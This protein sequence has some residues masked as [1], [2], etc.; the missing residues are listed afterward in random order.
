[1]PA[2]FFIS[3]PVPTD[4]A[5]SSLPVLG[6]APDVTVMPQGLR[7]GTTV[8][9]APDLMVVV[10]LA[11]GMLMDEANR[12]SHAFSA[13]L[14]LLHRQCLLAWRVD[15]LAVATPLIA[16]IGLLQFQLMPPMPPLPPTTPAS[17]T[18]SRAVPLSRFALL[19][20]SEGEWLLESGRSRWVVRLTDAGVSGL[21][22]LS[23]L[24][25]RAAP[26]LAL[27]CATGMLDDRDSEPAARF[28]EPH[29]RYFASRSRIDFSMASCRR[30]ELRPTELE[31]EPGMRAGP[32]GAQRIALPVPVGPQPD[33]PSLWTATETRRTV[34]LFA[35][36]PVSLAALG[37]LLWR[38]LRVTRHLPRDP[39]NPRSYEQIYRPVASGGAMGGSDLW[40]MCMSV[41]G[42]PQGVW[43]YDPFAHELV[44]VAS[45][46]A[47]V[48]RVLIR[49]GATPNPPPVIGLITVRHARA[50]WKYSGITYALELKDIGVILH[51]LQLVAGAVGLGM[52]MWGSGPTEIIT[53][54]LGLDPE[55]DAP[56]GE[57][58]LGVAKPDPH[59]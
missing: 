23:G 12:P 13:A 6:L 34:R 21:A 31:P 57:F 2:A 59:E 10:A 27:L 9:P 44:A 54:L 25:S 8:T 38:T 45:Q 30:A 40:L 37:T 24:G 41:C 14:D 33:E 52:C 16:G 55:V 47:D 29:D 11:S 53:D 28:W 3:R 5:A 17:T 46:P 19:R 32:G 50:A 35:D 51:A 18:S 4:T 48:E 49:M 15:D 20:R 42:V 58:V 43:R 26:F 39:A 56:V 1:M 7:R 22:D 36:Q